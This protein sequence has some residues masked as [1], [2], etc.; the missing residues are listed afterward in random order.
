MGPK[1]FLQGEWLGHPLHPALVHI[2]TALWPAALVFDVLTQFD[3]GG[4]AL[5]RASFY[6]IALGLAVALL[7]VPTGLADWWDIGRDKPAWKLGLW[8]MG[9]NVVVAAIAAANLYLRLGDE[10]QATVVPTTPLLLSLLATALLLVS[11]YL[12]GRMVFNYGTS[13]ARQSKEKWRRHAEAGGARLP[14]QE[15]DS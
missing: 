15:K 9:I 12:G 5:V 10:L 8:H 1:Q 13:I 11:G 2:P 4:N 6:A 14:T 3:V 7:A